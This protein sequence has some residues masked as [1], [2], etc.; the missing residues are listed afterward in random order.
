MVLLAALNV[1][2][3]K[4]TGQEDIIIG[5]PVNGRSQA[6]L[7]KIIGVF[8][9]TLAMRNYPASDLSF[10]EFLAGVRDNT[11]KA[12]NN[13]DYQFETMIENLNLRRDFSRN[14]LFDVMF[15]LQNLDISARESTGLRFTPLP[16]A[17]KTA[18]FDLTLEAIEDRENKILCNIEYCTRLFRRETVLQFSKHF[19]NVL[20]AVT[21][22]PAIE[23]QKVEILSPE[24]KK[25]ILEGFND[26]M[27]EYVKEKLIYELFEEQAHRTADQ[28]ALQF[29]NK[30]LTYQ[31]L[32]EQSDSLARILREH[33]VKPDLPVAIMVH[34]SLE[35]LIG[36][37]A[38]LKAS[39]PYLPIDP[40]YP[41]ERI[42]YM[43]ED[44][45]AKVLLTQ[46]AL[47]AKA[48]FNGT[49][50][51]VNDHKLYQGKGPELEKINTARNLAYIIYTSGSTGQPKGVMIEHRA[52][53]NFIIG[54][55]R[56]IDFTAAKTILALTTVSFDIFGLE[57]I[58]ALTQGLKI[59]IAS[60][61]EQLDPNL[62][63]ET[64]IQNRIQMLQITP[65]R[66]QLLLSDERY[67]PC[68]ENLTE[69]MI[70]GE[71]LPENLLN[72][73]QKS[74]RAKIYNMYGPTETTIWSTVK[75]LT[76]ETTVNIGVPI[77]NTQI[78]IL[79][80]NHRPQPI[81]VVGELYIAGDGLARG[82]WKRPELTA[83]KFIDIQFRVKS[84]EFKVERQ[85][86]GGNEIQL[87]TINSKLSTER[88]YRTGDLARWMP[89]GNI[90]FL[91][92]ADQ[93]VKIRGYR[94]ELGEIENQL[95]THEAIQSA[96]VIDETDENGLKS[97]HAYYVASRELTVV[98]LRNHLG[99]TLPDY[100]IPASFNRLDRI[101]QTPNGKIDRKAL[102][103]AGQRQSDSGVEY[104]APETTFENQL[105]GIWQKLLKGAR[106]GIHD[107][108]FTLGG[109]SLL[110]VLMHNR[111]NELYPGKIE[112]TDIFAYPTIARLAQ[113]IDTGRTAPRIQLEELPFPAE[114]F[115]TAAEESKELAFK[116]QISG[117]RLAKLKNIA[118]RTGVTLPE[119]LLSNYFYLL[120][121]ISEQS[122]IVVQIIVPDT[123]QG[124]PLKIDLSEFTALPELFC[125]VKQQ[126]ANNPKDFI[127]DIQHLNKIRIAKN[128]HSII[129]FFATG[130]DLT[131]Q[132][133][134]NYDL[135]LNV[136]SITGA[137]IGFT[138]H[139]NQQRLK[140]S[141][142]EKL[143][144][145]YLKLAD[146]IIEKIEGNDNE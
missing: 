110:V 102:P 112:I 103:K 43:L 66:L 38:I 131:S 92:R 56:R 97:L 63:S 82:Y 142:V 122:I 140:Q 141:Q 105:A 8:I 22:N 55:T 40:E 116:F 85:N 104:V 106:V 12:F 111:L 21:T 57:T 24:E 49:I 61:K 50:L 71:A 7:E 96:A 37:M 16:F 54:I 33:G 95:L 18:K 114:Y 121:E 77:A 119:L 136:K 100:M 46:K 145:A 65:S 123:D 134:A 76:N 75:D 81:G 132:T 135:M 17:N 98:E 108:F 94:I 60:E 109:N 45:E 51:D 80:P 78:Y 62:L 31:E 87:S 137:E 69:I 26:T 99:I 20:T 117:T 19:I 113:F 68:L 35:M 83:E 73:V 64:M 30:T 144:Q 27:V 138:C 118:I 32:N 101:P 28:I 79:D 139:Y 23:L 88:L 39:A 29:Q 52:V 42:K 47:A 10:K 143:I 67:R 130:Y 86:H 74:T 2:L 90:E 15:I 34:R 84:E 14:P 120:A 48:A 133:L 6:G 4:Y 53:H 3:F 127:Y 125:A 129:P 146:I 58:L 107:N 124:F 70:G 128:K 11:L 9:N 5:S 59:V 126:L 93:Q 89:D 25:L 91:G 72:E 13:Q 1:L 115:G 41:G 44:S 36:I